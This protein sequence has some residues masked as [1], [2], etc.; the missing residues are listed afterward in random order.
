MPDDVHF[1]CRQ[2]DGHRM[3][4]RELSTWES[5]QW[6]VGD[7]TADRLIGGRL[8]LHE[9]QD[10]RAW[11]GGIIE[12]WRPVEGNPSRKIFTYRVDGPF[13]V[14]HREGWAQEISLVRR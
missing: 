9:R 8:Y 5:G 11:H 1:I 14:L 12:A 6:T 13:R 2:G 10:E 7:A 3:I 4:D